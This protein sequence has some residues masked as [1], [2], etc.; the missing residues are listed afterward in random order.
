MTPGKT[1][2]LTRWTF[3]GN[4]ISLLFNMLSSFFIAFLPMQLHSNCILLGSDIPLVKIG[5]QLLD[6]QNF[7]ICK[8]QLNH[9]LFG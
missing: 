8:E 5:V 1:I 2:A 7:N 4:V 3:V 6:V 9:I